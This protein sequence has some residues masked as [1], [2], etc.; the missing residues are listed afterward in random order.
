M[1]PLSNVGEA[2][3]QARSQ[4]AFGNAGTG[5]GNGNLQEFVAVLGGNRNFP[6]RVALRDAVL[7]RVFDE[8]L[9]RENGNQKSAGV[10]RGGYVRGE[11]I[12][13]PQTLDLEIGLHD[14]Q[15]LVK[16]KEGAVTLQGLAEQI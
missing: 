15:F 14:R 6:A 3:A 4:L 8:R 1:K 5:I 7:D 9:N 12:A 13:E 11:A 2:H 16:R 10:R